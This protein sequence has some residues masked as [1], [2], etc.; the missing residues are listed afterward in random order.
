VISRN[1]LSI[2]SMDWLSAVLRSLRLMSVTLAV[3]PRTCVPLTSSRPVAI[4]L[5]DRLVAISVSSCARSRGQQSLQSCKSIGSPVRWLRRQNQRHVRSRP[6]DTAA[7][8]GALCSAN[9]AAEAPAKTHPR[10]ISV[11]DTV[12]AFSRSARRTIS[13]RH[14]RMFQDFHWGW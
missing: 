3:R 13:A 5:C 8:E 9:S 4:G 14:R 12:S 7:I 1:S 10:S 2:S 11:I 6:P